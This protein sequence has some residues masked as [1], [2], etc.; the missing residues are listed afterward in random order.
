MTP[1]D[2]PRVRG[3]VPWPPAAPL[4][5]DLAQL[6]RRERV[7]GGWSQKRLAL[8]IGM[9][10]SRLSRYE[11]RTAL[12]PRVDVYAR[13]FH[14]LGITIRL[15][16]Q[17]TDEAPR[18]DRGHAF[19]LGYV[20]RRLPS[21]WLGD[22]EVAVRE[23][24]RRGWIDLLLFHPRSRWLLVV[25]IKTEVH[26]IG[27]TLRTL[28]WHADHALSAAHARG[29]R[30]RSVVPVLIVLG[31]REATDR[32]IEAQPLLAS[33]LPG[34]GRQLLALL[35]DDDPAPSQDG[36]VG[37]SHPTSG[38]VAERGYVGL[39]DPQSRRAGWLQSIPTRGRRPRTRWVGLAHFLRAIEGRRIRRPLSRR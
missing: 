10:Q 11:T 23:G 33:A 30:P 22:T 12:R 26:D 38:P 36:S 19:A 4:E 6:L 1:S 15:D 7:N 13:A 35:A 17:R 3:P 31:T 24:R 21:A 16:A 37:R 27:E 8:R 5:I 29:W 39:I 28:R 14:V 2:A 25:E 34:D 9:S 20:L 18:R 32:L